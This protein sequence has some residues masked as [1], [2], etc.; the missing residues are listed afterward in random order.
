MSRQEQEFWNGIRAAG[1]LLGFAVSIH[2]ITNRKWSQLHS[3]ALMLTAAATIGP[4][5]RRSGLM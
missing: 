5:L 3:I 1:V 2:G 4:Q